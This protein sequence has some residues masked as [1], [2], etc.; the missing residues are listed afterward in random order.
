M[1]NICTLL[2][3]MSALCTDAVAATT[4]P[5]EVVVAQVAGFSGSRAERGKAMHAGIK[6][7]IDKVNADG[8]IKGARIRL[9]AKDDAYKPEQTVRLVKE[10]IAAE[11]PVAFIGSTGTANVEALIKERVLADANVPLVGVSGATSMLGARNVF[12]IKATYHDEADKLFEILQSTGVNGVSV[13]YQDDPSGADVL[14]GLEKAS[15]R[16]GIPI[17]MKASFPRDTT[18][19]KAAAAR[20]MQAGPAFIY[21]AA[22]TAGAIGFIKEYRELG[23]AAQIYGIST[24]DGPLLGAKL[25]TTARGFAWAT[26]VPAANAKGFAIVREYQEL[27]ARSNDPDLGAVS[28]EGYI[29]AKV[30]V[31]AMRKAKTLKPAAVARA[32][33]A[34]TRLDLGDYV[35]DYSDT[36]RAGAHFVDFAIVNGQGQIV[37]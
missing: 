7:Y 27:A 29:A 21:L 10:T 37:H 11:R 14:A 4:P 16:T 13:V 25:G 3:A 2:L 6:L 34:T 30:L 12:T 35:I 26:V 23:G 36:K 19:L 20:L 17:A 22:P 9:I 33:A 5:R 1:K 8:G 24:I 31:H 15:A 18:D 32:L 28:L